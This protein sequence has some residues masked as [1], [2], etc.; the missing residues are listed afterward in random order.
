MII[1]SGFIDISGFHSYLWILI[2]DR[3][4]N[5]LLEVQIMYNFG[6]TEHTDLVHD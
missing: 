2:G 4:Y 3:G 6:S 1:C 5:N